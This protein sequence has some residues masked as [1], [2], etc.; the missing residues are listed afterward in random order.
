MTRSITARS[1]YDDLH[2]R[3]KLQWIAGESDPSGYS[4]SPD[5]LTTRPAVAGFLNLIHPNRIQVLG[6]EEIRYLDTLHGDE[7]QATVA[8]IFDGRPLAVLVGD[9]LELPDL[10]LSEA[11]GK[12][13]ALIRSDMKAFKLVDYLQYYVSTAL[14]RKTTL[15]GV[16]MEVFTI[17]VLITGDPGCGK[18][19]LALE[20]LNRGHRLI[21]DDAPEFTRITPE[22]IDGTCPEALQDCLEVRGLGIL[23]VRHMFGDSAVK[24][25]KFLRLIIHLEIPGKGDS[26]VHQDRLQGS[27]S[28]LEVLEINIPRITLPVMAGRNLSIIAE[29]AV[30][31]FMLKMKGYDAASSFIERHS[32]ILRRQN[33][34]I[35]D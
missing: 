6:W 29:A 22:I 32:R 16:F 3:L 26:L 21:A 18:S 28:S 2:E 11:A 5:D 25:N 17:G 13:T 15:H 24:L 7:K 4:I 19:E 23:N 20:L 12:H 34:K 27:T 8:R 33:R 31:D 35:A 1:L 9:G 30:R 14:A 10:V